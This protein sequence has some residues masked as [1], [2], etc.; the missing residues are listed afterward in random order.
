MPGNGPG[1]PMPLFPP[2]RIS[3]GLLCV[4]DR[5]C[6]SWLNMSGDETISGYRMVKGRRS[7]LTLDFWW[8][9]DPGRD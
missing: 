6:E 2:Y 1:A 9:S 4:P 7:H 5:P 3:T 8:L